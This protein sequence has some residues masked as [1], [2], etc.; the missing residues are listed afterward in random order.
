MLPDATD[1]TGWQYVAQ[2]LD[3]QLTKTRTL[4][5]EALELLRRWQNVM[6][7]GDEYGQWD[8]EVREFVLRTRHWR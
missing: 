1:E 4:F 7:A 5:N 6:D 8:D 3:A 2:I